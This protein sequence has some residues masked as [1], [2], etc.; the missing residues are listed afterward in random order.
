MEMLRAGIYVLFSAGLV[1]CSQ[2]EERAH[3]RV[4]IT[5]DGERCRIMLDV[6]YCARHLTS[7]GPA[8]VA[9]GSIFVLGDD[10]SL[11]LRNT[12]LQISVS[13]MR[14]VLERA[15]VEQDKEGR[16]ESLWIHTIQHKDERYRVT[17]GSTAP[18]R[19]VFLCEMGLSADDYRALQHATVRLD[20]FCAANIRR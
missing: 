14:E 8:D 11:S 6:E 18:D 9:S 19:R 10:G 3:Q 12:T 5:A 16:L 17:F 2:G 15:V 13:A 1:F 7:H 20:E 4:R